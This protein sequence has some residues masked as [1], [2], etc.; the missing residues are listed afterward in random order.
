MNLILVQFL[1]R[2]AINDPD[3]IVVLSFWI[4]S[5]TTETNF[6]KDLDI[7]TKSFFVMDLKDK[8]TDTLLW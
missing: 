8:R 7:K 6:A 3:K 4:V 5:C 1:I 2:E